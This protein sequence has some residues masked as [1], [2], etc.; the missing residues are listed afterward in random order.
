MDA[1]KGGFGVV[2]IFVLMQM[3]AFA[4]CEHILNSNI[5]WSALNKPKMIPQKP[6]GSFTK[7]YAHHEFFDQDQIPWTFIKDDR[8]LDLNTA[9][10][11]ISSLIYSHFQILTPITTRYM[12]YAAIRSLETNLP[13]GRLDHLDTQKVRGLI[14]VAAFLQD[15]KRLENDQSNL[16]LKQNEFIALDF[17][18][19][20]GAGKNGFH[21]KGRII[22]GA[23]GGYPAFKSMAEALN[24]IDWTLLDKNHPWKNLNEE[25]YDF[26]LRG[27]DSL[28]DQDIQ[29]YVEA[30]EYSEPL[31]AQYMIEKLIHNRDIFK[32]DLRR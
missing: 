28:S 24:Q 6:V 8:Y 32:R 29:A 15:L 27:F 3:F 1:S 16:L 30:A 12:N 4:D 19:T 22:S 2:V 23:V 18:Q 20:L 17:S 11:V 13:L 10:S 26:A 31:D 9:S 25:D 14:F 7:K 21:K 5:L